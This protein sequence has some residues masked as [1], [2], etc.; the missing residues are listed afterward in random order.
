MISPTICRT[1]VTK[2]FSGQVPNKVAA[3][4]AARSGYSMQESMESSFDSVRASSLPEMEERL[5][6]SF[7]EPRSMPLV[8]ILVR[9]MGRD[10]LRQALDSVARQTYPNIEVVVVDALAAGH[11]ELPVRCGRFP[12]RFIAA[13]SPRLRSLAAN[14]GLDNARGEYLLFLD[15]DDVIFP[16]HVDKLVKHLEQHDHLLAAYTG[17][18]AVD[19]TGKEIHSF[20][21]VAPGVRLL[22]SNFVP[23]HS[24]LFSR[25]LVTRHRCRF[26]PSLDIYEDWDFWL[27]VG[28]YTDFDFIPGV[29]ALY[30]VDNTP[31]HPVH[32]PDEIRRSAERIYLKWSTF[33]QLNGL[34]RLREYVQGVEKEISVQALEITR[35]NQGL[36]QLNEVNARLSREG[37]EME[38]MLQSLSVELNA[39]HHSLS[40]RITK[41]LRHLN[42]MLVRFRRFLRCGS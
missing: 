15:D 40:W 27:Q 42:A 39:I 5:D 28:Q 20:T 35:L 41:P 21:L 9:S 23:I 8:S 30:R 3:Y 32:D 24:V 2:P 34:H 6:R 17:V 4:D 7:D 16:G 25:L 22:L 37:A 38:T 18:S 10:S 13:T 12:L 26:D 33:G 31:E 19:R 1:Q 29:S 14:V 36:V 11:R